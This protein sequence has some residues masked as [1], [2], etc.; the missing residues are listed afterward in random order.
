MDKII[1]FLLDKRDLQLDRSRFI[2]LNWLD[3]FIDFFE[4]DYKALKLEEEEDEREATS[5]SALGPSEGEEVKTVGASMLGEY[6][7]S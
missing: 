2:G 5:G 7:A 1:K 3:K 6:K 4:L